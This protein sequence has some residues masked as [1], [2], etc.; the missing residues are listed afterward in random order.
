MGFGA[1]RVLDDERLAAGVTLDSERRAN[2]EILTWVI[3]GEV[4]ILVGEATRALGPSGFSCV[5]AGS[6]IDCATRNRGDVPVHFMQLWLQPVAVN[7]APRCGVHQ[8]A[9]AELLDGFRRIAASADAGADI[10]LRADAN[11]CIARADSGERLR[12]PLPV[13]RKAWVQVL[14]GSVDCGELTAFA[15]DGIE[16]RDQA[17]IEL[18]VRE[19]AEI[20]LIDLA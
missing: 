4:E 10:E 20:L 6:G 14:R 11:V 1:L 8:Y 12:Y 15:G 3:D 9:D 5:S 2:M 18:R 7:A 19:D 17:N 13:T 16:V